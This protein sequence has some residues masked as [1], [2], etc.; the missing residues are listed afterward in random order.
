MYV[1]MCESKIRSAQSGR[2]IV[3]HDEA[4]SPLGGPCGPGT[5]ESAPDGPCGHGTVESAP[6]GPCGPCG[7]GTVESAPGGPCG[8][9]IDSPGGPYGPG[10]VES[11]LGGPCG[12]TID[13]GLSRSSL[14]DPENIL[15]KFPP[16]WKPFY[17]QIMFSDHM[18]RC[19]RSF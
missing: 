13:I 1:P 17:L 18:F 16:D 7:P 8:P 3:D 11:A 9:T 12:P 19:R 15:V 10:T 2:S 5:I 6:G 4:P 14:Y